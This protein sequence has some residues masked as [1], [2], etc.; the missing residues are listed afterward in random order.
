MKWLSSNIIIEEEKK[1][2]DGQFNHL[3]FALDKVAFDDI[4]PDSN[5]RKSV[6]YKMRLYE[7]FFLD[8]I[9]D[10]FFKRNDSH[11]RPQ[12]DARNSEECRI[13]PYHELVC[14]KYNQSDWVPMTKQ[15]PNFHHELENSFS[16]ALDETITYDRAK[17]LL[18]EA[19]GRLN[20]V[21]IICFKFLF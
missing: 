20:I 13:Q 18:V 3:M 7:A 14:D 17:R 10:E 21:S 4:T 16:L 1:W 15:F 9:H 19:R 8:E 6:K 2:V 12:L 5:V 11:T